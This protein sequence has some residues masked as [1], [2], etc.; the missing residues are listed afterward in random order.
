MPPAYLKAPSSLSTEAVALA[1][2]GLATF[3]SRAEAQRKAKGKPGQV[4][5]PYGCSYCGQWHVQRNTRRM[6]HV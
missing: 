4:L 3:H 1:C 5:E 6:K 2:A